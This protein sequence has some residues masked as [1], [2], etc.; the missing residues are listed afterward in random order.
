LSSSVSV[1]LWITTATGEPC[2]CQ[3][4]LPPG[5]IVICS[6]IVVSPALALTSNGTTIFPTASGVP[7]IGG[8]AADVVVAATSTA[9][10]KRV[11]A[12]VTFMSSSFDSGSGR[13]LRSGA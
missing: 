1:P 4:K 2:E 8:P 10:A 11:S 6:T 12:S 5:L 3:P 7:M 13:T 9:A